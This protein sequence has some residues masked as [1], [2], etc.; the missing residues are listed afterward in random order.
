VEKFRS[1][2]VLRGG[3]VVGDVKGSVAVLVDD[4]ISS[5]QTLARAAASCRALGALSV[6]ALASHGV[7]SA[8]AS[9]ILRASELER[10]TVLN[11]I[12]PLRLAPD[13]LQQRVQVLDCAPLLAGVIGRLHSHGS[14]VALEQSQELTGER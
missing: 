9:D 3:S 10:V 8:Q 1:E 6:H 12:E 13:L 5:G 4:L 7:F 14:L 11:T 2:G